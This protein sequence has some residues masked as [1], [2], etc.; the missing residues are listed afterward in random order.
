MQLVVEPFEA[1]YRGIPVAV[2]RFECWKCRECRDRLLTPEQSKQL[3][4][5]V[6]GQVRSDRAVMSPERIAAIRHRL[7]LTQGDL[8][9]LLGL[10]EKVVTRWENGR[11]VPGK[12]VDLLLKLLDQ[13]P[14]LLDKLRELRA[15][16]R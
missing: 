1:V 2:P 9:D 10:G 5:L 12:P 15:S 8:E 14:R 6:K 4:T 16:E 13:E 3:S 11:V 7:G